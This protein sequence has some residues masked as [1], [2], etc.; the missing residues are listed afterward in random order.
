LT[1]TV[2][3]GKT[4]VAYEINDVLSEMETPNTMVDL[5]ALTS[6]P[7]FRAV[8]SRAEDD[9]TRR[10]APEPPGVAAEF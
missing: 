9:P 8:W 7:V 2:G 1:G 3:S 10:P 5:D 4:T 6:S